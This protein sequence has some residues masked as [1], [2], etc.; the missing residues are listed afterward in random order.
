MI[1]GDLVEADFACSERPW[2]E[3]SAMPFLMVSLTR[4]DC[5]V[6]RGRKFYVCRRVPSLVCPDGS[7]M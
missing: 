1:L 5:V 3:V 6:E 4:E 2:I 7:V